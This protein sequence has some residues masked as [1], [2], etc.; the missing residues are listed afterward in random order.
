MT[1]LDDYLSTLQAGECSDLVQNRG[2]VKIPAC[3]RK[4]M[5]VTEEE[6]LVWFEIISLTNSEWGY[7]NPT[8]QTLGMYLGVTT[9]TISKRLKNIEAKD[10]IASRGPKGRKRRYYPSLTLHTNPYFVLSET[11]HW[12]LHVIAKHLSESEAKAGWG[13]ILLQFV[14]VKEKDQFT[15]ADTYGNFLI[16]L[17]D[18]PDRVIEIRLRFLDAITE[19][20]KKHAKI[21][22][23]V[24][25]K[26]E[27]EE[28]KQQKLM[29]EKKQRNGKKNYWT[30]YPKIPQT[31]IPRD[32]HVD[33]DEFL[34]ENERGGKGKRK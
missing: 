22:L 13:D 28:S 4:M 14:N 12:A 19:Y 15:S 18:N 5:R 20:L 30:N 23:V 21:Y 6:K 27:L 26:A 16:E 34:F 24:D 31:A 8:Q 1:K 2:Y 32:Y 10:L 29:R 3:L 17:Q 9:G 7:A 25:W 11:F 33:D